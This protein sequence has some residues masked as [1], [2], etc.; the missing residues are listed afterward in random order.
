MF[1]GQYLFLYEPKF[2]LESSDEKE[3]VLNSISFKYV[4]SNAPEVSASC[5]EPFYILLRFWDNMIYCIHITNNI[6]F[7]SR[8]KLL[9]GSENLD[10][11]IG[12]IDYINQVP[13]YILILCIYILSHSLFVKW[14]YVEANKICT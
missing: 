7:P 6:C 13:K 4:D 5:Y 9:T 12:W 1:R 3:L 2:L 10:E 8:H 11:V 14:D